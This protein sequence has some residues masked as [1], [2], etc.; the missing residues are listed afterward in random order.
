MKPVPLRFGL[1]LLA[2]AGVLGGFLAVRWWRLDPRSPD[3]IALAYAR[4][5]YARDYSAA[6]ELIAATEKQYKTRDQYLAENASFDGLERDLAYALAGW[7]EYAQTNVQIT[8]NQATVA[9][10]VKVPNGNQPQMYEILRAGERETELTAVERQALFERLQSLYAAGQ[11]EILEGQQSFTLV[12]DPAGFPAWLSPGAWRVTLDWAG[13][14]VVRLTAEVDPGLPWDFY[15]LQSEV[16][17]LPG[18]T[19]TAVYRVTNRSDHPITGKAKHFVLPEAYE[20][21]FTSI[22]CFCFIQQ[23][24]E[25]GESEDMSL[26]F[27]IDYDLPPGVREFENKYVFYALESFPED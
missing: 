11:I 27:R 26:V 9:T 14:V 16:R 7:I 25:P 10:Q 22:Q 12:R 13:A 5:V 8:G 3:E 24:L 4:A 17:A 15:P 6:W 23:T 18:E 2:L 1:T 21:Y 19:L 20:D